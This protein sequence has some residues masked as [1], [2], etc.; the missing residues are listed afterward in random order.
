MLMAFTLHLGKEK[1]GRKSS[2]IRLMLELYLN[3]QRSIRLVRFE[4]E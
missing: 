2:V 4:L 3:S 1:L